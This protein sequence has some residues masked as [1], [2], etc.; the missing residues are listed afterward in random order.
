MAFEVMGSGV[1]AMETEV[2][3]D[4]RSAKTR[5]RSSVKTLGRRD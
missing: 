3:R 2:A 1:V 5:G 4:K